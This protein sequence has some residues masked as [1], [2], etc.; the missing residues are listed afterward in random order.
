MTDVT[1]FSL[2]IF[3]ILSLV[4]ALET[5]S[6]AWL[7]AG[8]F[9]SATGILCRQYGVFVPLAFFLAWPLRYGINIR[10]LLRGFL[11]LLVMCA[12][13]VVFVALM[14]RARVLPP[15]LNAGADN[16]LEE[17]KNPAETFKNML[18]WTHCASIH[19]GLF[20]LPL[21][22]FIRGTLTRKKR[23]FG[24]VSVAL[25][26]IFVIVEVYYLRKRGETMPLMA[27]AVI[28]NTEST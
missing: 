28:R 26:V 19:V 9:F 14:K 24:F 7:C 16:I 21:A 13:Y 8:T 1:F 23:F 2:E 15:S 3:A 6:T 12:A 18:F 10:I 11:P 4:H 17:L 20:L 25:C 22:I 5:D 27:F